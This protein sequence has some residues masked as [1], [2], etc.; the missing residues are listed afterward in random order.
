MLLPKLLYEPNYPPAL[1]AHNL[2]LI[3]VASLTHVSSCSGSETAMEQVCSGH[4]G[5]D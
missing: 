3:V 5:P 4:A 2:F 1:I